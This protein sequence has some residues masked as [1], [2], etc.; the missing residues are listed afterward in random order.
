MLLCFLAVRGPVVEP[1]NAVAEIDLRATAAETAACLTDVWSRL[2]FHCGR[3]TG[4]CGACGAELV[5]GR[6]V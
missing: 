4:F 3:E 1:L 5:S 2:W 6:G